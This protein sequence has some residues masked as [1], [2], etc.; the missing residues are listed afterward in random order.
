MLP[1][2]Y[3]R[4]QKEAVVQGLKRKYFSTAEEDVEKI[5]AFDQQRR[6]TQLDLDNTLS[7]SN[8]LSK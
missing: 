3:L 1:I 8:G 5:L 4:D 2:N 7:R 6:Q